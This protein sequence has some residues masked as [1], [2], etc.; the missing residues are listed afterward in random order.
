[1][2]ARETDVALSAN[3]LASEQERG[4]LKRR[5]QGREHRYAGAVRGGKGTPVRAGLVLSWASQGVQDILR[6]FCKEMTRG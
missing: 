3:S 2:L 6:R 4:T 1:M 5:I